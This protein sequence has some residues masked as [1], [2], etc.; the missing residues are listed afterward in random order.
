[1][2]AIMRL[3]FV[4]FPISIRNSPASVAHLI[5][6]THVIQMFVSPDPAMQRLWAESQE[7]L[8]VEIEMETLPMVQ[9]ADISDEGNSMASDELSINFGKLKLDNVVYILHSSGKWLAK[10]ETEIQVS[11]SGLL[12]SLNPPRPT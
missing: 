10:L 9:F 6:R 11:Q 1:M 12:N 5:R 4:P 8:E 7:L 2:L 3:G